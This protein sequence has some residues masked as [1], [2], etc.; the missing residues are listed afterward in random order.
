MINHM[1]A[2]LAVWGF[3]ALLI[4]LIG[5]VCAWAYLFRKSIDQN[6]AYHLWAIPGSIVTTLS[7][8]T[9]LVYWWTP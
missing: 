2:L 8:I 4:V 3:L 5:I 9:I 1:D 7:L 6:T